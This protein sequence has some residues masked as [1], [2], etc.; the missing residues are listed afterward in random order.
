ME[1]ESYIESQRHQGQLDSEG[2]FTIDTLAALRISLASA[3]PEPHYYLLL[4]LQGLIAARADRIEVAIGRNSTKFSF[5]DG[6][7]KFSD[8]KALQARVRRGLTLASPSAQDLVVAGM[9]TSV[10][11]EMD[12]ADLFCATDLDSPHHI[13][14]LSS[15]RVEIV[16]HPQ[17]RA[18]TEPSSVLLH[19]N[20][21]RA[22]SFAWTRV[23]GAR[24][25]ESEILR[26][27]EHAEPAI[28]VAGLPTSPR[29]LWTHIDPL[30]T[31]GP[32]ILLEAALLAEA[33]SP[34][35]RAYSVHPMLPAEN[36]VGE[37]ISTELNATLTGSPALEDQNLPP[38]CLFRRAFSSR[39]EALSGELSP[40]TWQ[41]RRW[42]FFF[43]SH[44]RA[45]SEIVWIRNG[46]TLERQRLDLGWPG[47][48]VL[49]PAEN[50]DLDASGFAIV[51]NSNYEQLLQEAQELAQTVAS[52]LTEAH[53][54][55]LLQ[56]LGQPEQL[57]SISA[58]FPWLK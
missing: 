56:R 24:R 37:E 52:S 5:H 25:E 34:A 27:F 54:E 7:Q 36:E 30:G 11:Q 13:L 15:S 57:S 33:G 18:S 55:K 14:E 42:S 20:V 10:G 48:V 41:R 51:A 1:M 46:L 39:G 6:H 32:V 50:L 29:P 9:A 35:H 23:W 40:E 12:R 58:A 19:R 17:R 26:R 21:N 3:L 43:T 31:A 38:R 49:A 8:L 53:V 16:T 28:K 45:E 2:A 47:L 4:I 22:Q 44:Q